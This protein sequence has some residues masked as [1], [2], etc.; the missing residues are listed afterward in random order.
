MRLTDKEFESLKIQPDPQEITVLRTGVYVRCGTIGVT[1]FKR[2]KH[3][4]VEIAH[5]NNYKELSL[6]RINESLQNG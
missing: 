2:A 1:F 3:Q 5:V 6:K 4:F